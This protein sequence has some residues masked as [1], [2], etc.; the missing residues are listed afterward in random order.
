[1]PPYRRP[2]FFNQLYERRVEGLHLIV[3]AFGDEL[4]NL[5][6]L[7]WIPMKSVMRPVVTTTSQ[8]AAPLAALSARKTLTEELNDDDL[9]GSLASMALIWLLSC[10]GKRRIVQITVLVASNLLSA[11][12]NQVPGLRPGRGLSERSRS[13]GSRFIRMIRVLPQDAPQGERPNALYALA[14]PR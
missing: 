2:V 13:P 7:G 8:A 4:L 3:P 6:G 1:V 14:L 5:V 11:L 12:S 9:K 10:G